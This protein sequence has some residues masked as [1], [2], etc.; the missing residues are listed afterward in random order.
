MDLPDSVIC[1]VSYYESFHVSSYSFSGNLNSPPEIHVMACTDDTNQKSLYRG[2]QHADP[3]I[4]TIPQVIVL[5]TPVPLQRNQG[6]RL[7]YSDCMDQP[8]GRT[9]QTQAVYHR[10]N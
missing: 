4:Y 6:S 1:R 5:L 10:Q 9:I 3:S 2:Q 8:S 7:G